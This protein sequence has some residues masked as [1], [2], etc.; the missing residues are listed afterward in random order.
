MLATTVIGL[1]EAMLD[2]GVAYWLEERPTEGGRKVVV[3]GDP[4]LGARRRDAGGVQRRHD[5]A[6]VRRRL[7]H[8]ARTA[9]C[10]SRTA[11]TLG[12]TGRTPGRR[13]CRSRRRPTRR[14]GS[15]TGS[16]PP[17]AGGGSACGSAT[18]SGRRWPTSSTSWWRCRRTVGDEP[19]V[20]AAGH[21][22]YS[23]PRVSPGRR[24]ARVALVGPAVDAVGRLR[25][26]RR[27]ARRP[28][29]RSGPPRVV[30]G[31]TGEESVWDPG[32][33]PVGRSR[34]RVGSQRLVEPRAHPRG[35]ARDAVPGRGG[36]RLPPMGPRGALDRLLRRW[37]H[38]LSLRR[39]HPDAPR[40]ARSRDGGADRPRPAA[41]RVAVGPEHRGRGLDDRVHRRVGVAA[42]PGRVAGLRRA[43]RRGAPTKLPRSASTG[44]TCPSPRR[45]SFRPTAG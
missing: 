32:V 12:C 22:F 45:S 30:A 18:I 26:V 8:R 24:V 40:G 35:R 15:P 34:V 25:A 27:A 21:D 37:T 19:H 14:S 36:V 38:R 9:S 20:L 16:S 7:L 3:Q 33:E 2:D 28:T 44:R 6:R 10:S 31:R 4:L 42:D 5:G 17:T 39:R 43:L 11:R 13:R 41:R 23:S 1:G 29:R